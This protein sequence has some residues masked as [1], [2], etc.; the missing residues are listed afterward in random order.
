MPL[1]SVII[2]TF[3]RAKLIPESIESV[4]SQSFTD[5]EIIVIDDGSTDNTRDVV[6]RFPVKYVLQRNQGPASARNTGITMAKGKYVA[7][8]DSDDHMLENSLAKRVDALEKHPEAA[9]AF[10]QILLMDENGQLCGSYKAP[11]KSSCMLNGKKQ[12]HD[13]ILDNHIPTSTVMIRLG[14]LDKTGL[15]NPDFRHGSEDL[16]LWLRLCSAYDSVYIAEPLA[17]WRVHSHRI[18]SELSLDEIENAHQLIIQSVFSNPELSHR[19]TSRRNLVYSHLYRLLAGVA[20]DRRKMKVSRKF[21]VKSVATDPLG[22][23]NLSGI[24]LLTLLVKSILPPEF[25]DFGRRSKLAIRER[26]AGG[27]IVN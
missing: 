7:F 23:L 17:R 10:G 21:I 20:Y 18:T 12:M 1:V 22:M 27:G 9:F 8:L 11:Y 4:L 26:L 3:N 25:L 2:P 15:F 5:F 16:E 24:R 13:L 14:C 6:A 19:F